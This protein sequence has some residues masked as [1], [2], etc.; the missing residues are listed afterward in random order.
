MKTSRVCATS[1]VR[2]MMETWPTWRYLNHGLDVRE[3]RN[4]SP[5]VPLE[6]P[7]PGPWTRASWW[8]RTFPCSPGSGMAGT[9]A[10]VGPL[11]IHYTATMYLAKRS[12]QN[13]CRGPVTARRKARSIWCS[14]RIESLSSP[15]TTCSIAL[16][17]DSSACRLPPA[18]ATRTAVNRNPTRSKKITHRKHQVYR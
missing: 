11:S 15:R 3:S 13:R 10:V 2:A 8:S 1:T 12:T 9:L 5:V 7:W 18:R 14:S 4:A 16:N 6:T 17:D